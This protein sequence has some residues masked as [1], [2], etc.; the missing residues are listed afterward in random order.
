MSEK[1]NKKMNSYLEFSP[2]GGTSRCVTIGR[3]T[4]LFATG[5]EDKK[6]L[7]WTV[8]HL[9]KTGKPFKS[10]KGHTSPVTCAVFDSSEEQLVSGSEGGSLKMWNLI[11]P[12][13][14]KSFTQS[15][16]AAVK[17]VAFSPDNVFLASGSQDTQVRVWDTVERKCIQTFKHHSK[18]V[19][20]V[21]FSPDSRFLFTG[22]ED[23]TCGVVDLFEGKL[24][25]TFK[26]DGAVTAIAVCPSD[27][28]LATG[29]SDRV[30]KLWDLDSFE[31][32]KELPP[33]TTTIRSLQF[34]GTD[35][36][37]L[38][39]ASEEA[40]RVWNW[41]DE[42][43]ASKSEREKSEKD[44]ESGEG[45]VKL[46][47]RL[48]AK[49]GGC[50]V[51]GPGTLDF[52]VGEQHLLGCSIQ[53]GKVTMWMSLLRDVNPWCQY[54]AHKQQK[55]TSQ[56]QKAGSS[57]PSSSSASSSSSSSSSVNKSLTHHSS[58]HSIHSPAPSAS[59]ST[60]TSEPSF[61]V[62]GTKA[63]IHSSSN[64]KVGPSA[65]AES[66]HTASTQETS[67]DSSAEP[68]TTTTTTTTASSAPNQPHSQRAIRVQRRIYGES[69]DSPFYT[70]PPVEEH[71]QPTGKGKARALPSSSLV[72]NDS[73][74]SPR[75]SE[76]DQNPSEVPCP[77]V[78][79][80][81]SQ[82]LRPLLK[83][84]LGQTLKDPWALE[85]QVDLEEGDLSSDD[86]NGDEEDN[87]ETGEKNIEHDDDEQMRGKQKPVQDSETTEKPKLTKKEACQS[88]SSASNE[89]AICS[90]S[91]QAERKAVDS[92]E[93][94]SKFCGGES[95]TEVARSDE[96]TVSAILKRHKQMMTTMN[97][98][99]G[100][101]QAV[102]RVWELGEMKMMCE[103]LVRIDDVSV[104]CDILNELL[105]KKG[106]LT[107]DC[108]LIL[109][110]HL[111][112]CL[113]SGVDSYVNTALSAI[114]MFAKSFG[115]MIRQTRSAPVSIGVDLSAD[116]RREKCVLANRHFVFVARAL[117]QL[118]AQRSGVADSI[119]LRAKEV[120]K[121]IDNFADYS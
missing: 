10:L 120:K 100:S 93:L 15:H 71:Q 113:T 41:D 85:G 45:E 1:R 23:G 96:E 94:F 119:G 62:K 121:V 56:E 117:K 22:S 29:G 83:S 66:L 63:L 91:S 49:W 74:A 77:E 38:V 99:L 28:V 30:T 35:D 25:H 102:K 24:V 80:S 37:V 76:R 42:G 58:S 68:I 78:D 46:Y 39:V 31:L 55:S 69:P 11:E 21:C 50:S 115:S 116:E 51:G 48:E 108:A 107:L 87:I 53:Q 106:L 86:A 43:S 105:K 5:G 114:V 60:N 34:C 27:L 109:L 75:S 79:L 12:K 54:M 97:G 20:C 13:T 64:S 7:V 36:H 44:T 32:L 3:K 65:S 95:G 111:M 16:L 33:E 98:R 84:R 67:Q 82:R 104:T 81:S 110:P 73:S 112:T 52:V 70:G 103:S 88:D 47:D 72:S 4:H 89:S 118:A 9:R 59:H 57:Q 26:H 90:S 8:H 18:P 14:S 17:C 19:N 40:V 92:N 2:H 101:I 61:A 6:T